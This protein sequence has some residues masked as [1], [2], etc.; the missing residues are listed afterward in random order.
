VECVAHE[1]DAAG[2]RD[3]VSAQAVG[4]TLAVEALVA[5]AH[6]LGRTLKGRRGAEHALADQRVAA[7][8]APLLG[9]ERT[10]LVE[11]RVGDR[12]LADVVQLRRALDVVEHRFGHA[13]ALADR[14]GESR[15]LT[16]VLVQ[17]G[18]ALGEDAQDDVARLLLG[19]DAACALVRVHALVGRHQ[20]GGRVGRL[21]GHDHRSP[22]G[23]HAEPLAA[24]AE[25]LPAVGDQVL[26][27]VGAERSE[28]AE[29][30][31]AEPEGDAAPV[32][33]VVQLAPEAAQQEI[34]LE[35][36]EEVVVDLEA[37]EVEEHEQ[38]TAVG[39][40]ELLHE[41]PPVRQAGEGVVV[42]KVLELSLE[43]LAL[44]DVDDRAVEVEHLAVGAE[45]GAALLVHPALLAL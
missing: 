43:P 28:D 37:V 10:R 18:V 32:D 2:Q 41:P 13:H 45:D 42:G 33:R 25:R 3:L 22:R 44:A 31:A 8:E 38:M 7:H 39:G 5:R 36:P 1:H 15:D 9:F 24:F 14:S 6:D 30:V 40:L 29:L 21:V 35:V 19:G 17:L 34:A 12:D 16:G 23:L 11:D 4:I 27:V 20:R 26:A